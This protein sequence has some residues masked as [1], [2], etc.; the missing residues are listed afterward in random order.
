MTRDGAGPPRDE[1]EAY[2]D[3]LFDREDGLL[4][5]LRREME[6]RGFP[7]IQVPART[8]LLLHV[9]VKATGAR[10]VLEVGTL[11]G[12]SAIWMARALPDDG[13]LV[14]VE[15]S[16]KHAALARDFL[17]RGGQ[18]RVEVREGRAADILPKIGPDGSWDIVFLDADKESYTAYLGEARRLLRPGGL[19]LADNAFWGGR[20]L[21]EDPEEAATLGIQAFNRAVAEDPAF[22]ATILPVGDGVLAA[23]RR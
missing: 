2:A 6:V 21:E 7:M 20:V 10:R 9:L 17:E 4:A 8:G 23:V 22:V 3:R 13:R 15:K 12:Y 1:L 18:G 5:A 19:L 16:S 11:G 14:T